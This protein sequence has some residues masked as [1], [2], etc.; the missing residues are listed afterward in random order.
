MEYV[1]FFFGN[2]WHFCGMIL[3]INAVAGLIYAMRK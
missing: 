3:T 2:F 1:E